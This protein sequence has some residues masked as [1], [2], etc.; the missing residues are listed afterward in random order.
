MSQQKSLPSNFQDS[1]PAVGTALQSKLLAAA[2]SIFQSGSLPSVGPASASDELLTF[3]K[4]VYCKDVSRECDVARGQDGNSNRDSNLDSH[5]HNKAMELLFT[6][7]R[8][9]CS[10]TRDADVL[11][12]ERRAF[13]TCVMRTAS[14][15]KAMSNKLVGFFFEEVKAK[16]QSTHT[17]V[18]F[19]L[20]FRFDETPT[21]IRVDDMKSTTV[22]DPLKNKQK[23]AKTTTQTCKLLQTELQ[24]SVLLKTK[25]RGHSGCEEPLLLSTSVPT[26]L[27][28]L[29]RTTGRNIK[30]ALEQSVNIPNL[31]SMASYFQFKTLVF[32]ADEYP[33]N[34]L[35]QFG[36][37]CARPGWMRLSTL[38]DVHKGSTCQ[39]RVFDLTGPSISAVINLALSMSPAGSLGKMQ[40]ALSEILRSRFELRIGSPPCKPDATAHKMEVL[41]LYFAVPDAFALEVATSVSTRQRLRYGQ[42]LR[43]RAIIEHFLND[44]FRD[45]SKIIHWC[46]PGQYDSEEAA[47]QIFLKFMV[48][49]LLPCACPLFPRS[50][51]FGADCALDW[52]G[53]LAATHGLLT[54]LIEA[55]TGRKSSQTA[56]ALQDTDSLKPDDGGWGSLPALQD[57]QQEDH[58]AETVQEEAP[59]LPVQ[60]PQA[61]EPASAADGTFDW[62][63]YHEQ[64]KMSVG[65]WVLAKS[66]LG[67]SPESMLALM[68]QYMGPILHLMTS[69][70]YMSSNKFSKDQFVTSARHGRR[71]Y[72]ML[73]AFENR[74]TRRLI[75]ACVGLF[76]SHPVALAEIDWRQDANVLAFT[77][78]SRLLCSTFQLLHWRRSKYPYKLFS[79]LQSV[80]SA[81]IVFRDPVCLKDEWT[82]R[83]CQ[84]FPTEAEFCSNDCTSLIESLAVLCDTDIAPIERQHTIARRVICSRAALARAVA[85]KSLSADWLLR[86]NIQAKAN[87]RAYL[88]FDSTKSRNDLHKH[89]KKKNLYPRGKE[90]E[91]EAGAV[92]GAP[93]WQQP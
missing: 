67:P 3:V 4:G 22:P 21:K 66:G 79:C 60:F 27:Q 35:A 16:L 41:N 15:L 7:Y 19:V 23:L 42:K 82:R 24:V 38:C 64:L 11:G 29:D 36:M 26:P 14:V 63:K 69:L 56:Q 20:K 31:E 89:L 10:F 40:A 2:M 87:L 49:A 58:T 34:D 91:N 46:Q 81:K 84:V 52:V 73:A 8:R 76:R 83:L 43:Q 86:Q 90:R 5:G 1:S 74:N 77:M 12:L 33:A 65:E 37:Q 71:Q 88:Y 85:L 53:L 32:N 80:E 92:H 54:P 25:H 18:L 17:G 28:V 30:Q 72:R 9:Y 68:R 93:L 13:A 70:L 55:W 61:E 62:H 39:G 57:Q 47:L 6:P 50:R 75:A 44:D 51:W 48:P 59:G 45:H 78:I